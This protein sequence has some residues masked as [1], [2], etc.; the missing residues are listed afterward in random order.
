MSA[1][2]SAALGLTPDLPGKSTFRVLR[3]PR[4]NVSLQVARTPV[5]A[6]DQ[7]H[8]DLYTDDQA[9]EVRRLS[10]LGATYLRRND[11]P[12]DAYVVMADPEGNQFCVLA[13]K[14]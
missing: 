1:F 4:V 10:D 8:F 12:D 3:G 5:S 11:D 9:G 14:S 7:M 6:R 13:T 2:W